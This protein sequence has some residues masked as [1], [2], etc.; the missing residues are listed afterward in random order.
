[1]EIKKPRFTYEKVLR[2]T[3]E[4]R[5]TSTITTDE[6]L[7]N[8]G[9][10]GA[11]KDPAPVG[12]VRRA[13]QKSGHTTSGSENNLKLKQLKEISS[14]EKVFRKRTHDCG[15]RSDFP[16]IFMGEESAG[17]HLYETNVFGTPR[18]GQLFPEEHASTW[19]AGSLEFQSAGVRQLAPVVEQ[20]LE[21]FVE[22]C[23]DQILRL[24]YPVGN[25][26]APLIP[27]L[28]VLGLVEGIEDPGQ[29]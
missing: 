7:A 12:V 16:R 6:L 13:R 25:P 23:V 26:A 5:S 29:L 2:A 4:V 11:P 10:A 3:H 8:A 14:Y 22:V 9:T 15:F 18:K 20:Q 21:H 17:W 19:P 27:G 1:M 24:R 28:L